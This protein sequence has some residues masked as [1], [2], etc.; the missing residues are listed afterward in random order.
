[1]LCPNCENK[2]S[3]EDKFCGH[4]GAEI[5]TGYKDLSPKT[6]SCAFCKAE[7]DFDSKECPKCKRVLVETIPASQK[8]ES[9]TPEFHSL[10]KKSGIAKF[11]NWMKSVNY[12]KLVLN[13]HVAIL[14][15]VIFIVW[16]ATSGDSSYNSG[17]VKTPLPAPVQQV[18]EDIIEF[19]STTPAV[20][21]ANGTIIKKNT[22]YLYGEGKL[23]IDNGTGQDTVAKLVRGG[24]S[25][26]TVYIKANSKYT[27]SGI[28][29]G[30]YFLLFAH[31]ADWD[32]ENQ[33]FRRNFSTSRFDELFD[34]ITTE[35]YQYVYYSE[36]EVTLHPVAGGTAETS[37]VD[38]AQFNAY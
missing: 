3:R 37:S 19:T 34:F 24:S 33:V 13:K 29:D 20:S 4:C 22:A 23:C 25:I 11:I 16:I 17:G 27:I 5:K 38:L 9:Y 7:I 36:F 8:Y 6:K 32:S 31:G 28:S 18:S 2:I 12:S 21:L 10:T 15:V 30:T 14:A 1:M 35:D 26:F